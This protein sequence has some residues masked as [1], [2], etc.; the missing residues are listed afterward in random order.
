MSNDLGLLPPSSIPTVTPTKARDIAR[1]LRS[2]ADEYTEIGMY[3]EADRMAHGSEWWL[4]YAMTLERA[5]DA[6]E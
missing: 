5:N 1:S 3:D 4:A 2:L 6:K